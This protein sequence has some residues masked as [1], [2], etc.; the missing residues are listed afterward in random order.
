L[1]DRE[2]RAETDFE[3]I[4]S[5]LYLPMVNEAVRCLSYGVARQPADVDLGMVLGTGF[6]PFRGGPLRNADVMGLPSVVERLNKLAEKHG[7]RM[8]PD[9][10]LVEMALGGRRFYP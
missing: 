3:V 5:R 10:A 2:G 4:Q 9:P 1:I 6:P 7:E 8:A